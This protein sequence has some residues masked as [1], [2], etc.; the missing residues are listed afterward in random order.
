MNDSKKYT[1]EEIDSNINT[2]TY[3]MDNLKRERVEVNRN[4]GEIRKQI[5]FWEEMQLNQYKMF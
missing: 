3:R 2:L 1:Q 5:K 4:I